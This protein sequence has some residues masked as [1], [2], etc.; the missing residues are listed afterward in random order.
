[1][2]GDMCKKILISWL[3]FSLVTV[4]GFAA[5]STPSCRVGCAA[6]EGTTFQTVAI[7]MVAVGVL[8][9]IGIIVGCS[10]AKTSH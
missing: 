7:A 3:T 8:A 5:D 6:K 2:E 4:S 9:V 10:L 1:M